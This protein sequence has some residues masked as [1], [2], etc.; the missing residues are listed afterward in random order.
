MKRLALGALLLL[1]S[2]GMSDQQAARNS[3]QA[4]FACQKE[5]GFKLSSDYDARNEKARRIGLITYDADNGRK[6]YCTYDTK[7]GVATLGQ[8][9]DE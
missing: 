4:F 1:A 2:C 8:L 9:S 3:A 7:T 6:V 5:Y